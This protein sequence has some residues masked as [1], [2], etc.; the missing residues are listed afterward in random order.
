MATKVSREEIR[1]EVAKSYKDKIA[2]LERENA[3]L[4]DKIVNLNTE[5]NS[6]R[7]EAEQLREWTERMQ[8]FCN[9]DDS[10][11]EQLIKDAKQ[12]EELKE[13]VENSGIL[14]AMR[15]MSRYMA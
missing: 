8:D 12:R 7:A 4:R 5:N 9:M 14:S 10:E 1:R 15:M 11:R 3:Q 6:L 13:L 2:T